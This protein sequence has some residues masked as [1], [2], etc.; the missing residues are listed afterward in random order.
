MDAIFLKL[1]RTFR[2]LG[3][4]LVVVLIAI[5]LANIVFREALG[6]ALVWANEVAIALFVWIAFIGAGVSFADNARIR[7]TFLADMLPER[8]NGMLE[9][10]VTYVGAV[11]LA[12]FVATSIYVMYVHRHQTFTTLPVTVAW[13]WASVPIGT[14]LALL[15]WIR[16]GK[17]TP[18]QP[19]SKSSSRLAGT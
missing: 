8:A 19:D 14:L 3:V 12:G 13:E 4:A 7:F 2:I 15:G 9:V 18:S 6:I 11:L 1:L 10:F 5:V 17:W 16:N